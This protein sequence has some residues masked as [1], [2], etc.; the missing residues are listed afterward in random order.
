MGLHEPFHF[1]L[2]IWSAQDTLDSFLVPEA[3]HPRSH[4]VISAQAPASESFCEL[5]PCTS[6][7]MGGRSRP[8]SP[9]RVGALDRGKGVLQPVRGTEDQRRCRFPLR[10]RPPDVRRLRAGAR[11]GPPR[12]RRAERAGA[13][14][15]GPGPS[16]R[17]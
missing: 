9:V 16:A 3:S 13:G 7:A 8:C 10:R 11:R 6:M 12:E 5:R 15:L 14:V 1:P 2:C 17:K 4:C